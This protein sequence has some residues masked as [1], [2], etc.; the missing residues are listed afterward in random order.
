M[1]KLDAVHPAIDGNEGTR[2]RHLDRSPAAALMRTD[3]EGRGLAECEKTSHP[4]GWVG[5][6]GCLCQTS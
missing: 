4:W 2:R 6:R 1:P 3:L 5:A